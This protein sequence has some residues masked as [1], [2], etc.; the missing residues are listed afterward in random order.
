MVVVLFIFVCFGCCV[1]LASR[2]LLVLLLFLVGTW[3]ELILGY[4]LN[5]FGFVCLWVLVLWYLV[6][7]LF[8]LALVFVLWHS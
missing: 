5:C 4:C 2:F 3:F 7:L 8:R 6:C 1:S